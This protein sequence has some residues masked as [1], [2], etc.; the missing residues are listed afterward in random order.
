MESQEQYLVKMHQ[1]F[2]NQATSLIGTQTFTVT[3]TSY[4]GPIA[5]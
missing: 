3:V 5:N 4:V 1:A 2:N